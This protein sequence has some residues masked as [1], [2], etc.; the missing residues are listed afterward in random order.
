MKRLDHLSKQLGR[1]ISS[2]EEV[3]AK[4]KSIQAA[5]GR[6]IVNKRVSF[7]FRF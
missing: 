7:E 2:G 6:L 4:M 5:R 1:R 3:D